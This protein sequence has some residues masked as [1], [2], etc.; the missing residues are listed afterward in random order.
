VLRA[1]DALEAD[2]LAGTGKPGLPV[3]GTLVECYDEPI[4]EW[5]ID[6]ILE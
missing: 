3:V 5:G 2:A 1:A 6:T 4:N